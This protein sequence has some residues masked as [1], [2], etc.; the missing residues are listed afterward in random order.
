MRL[1][2]YRHS[3]T[4]HHSA[5]PTCR[6]GMAAYWFVMPPIPRGALASP[7]HRP[8]ELYWAI[9]STKPWL[10]GWGGGVGRGGGGS[11]GWSRANQNTQGGGCGP[12]GGGR[13][14]GG[15]GGVGK[16]QIR[17]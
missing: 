11:W 5:Q 9:V 17:M 2:P 8:Y 4:P 14:G 13:W 7:P 3:I 16:S 10:P 6:L 12:G 15:G 1:P